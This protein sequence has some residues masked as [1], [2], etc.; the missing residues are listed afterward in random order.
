MRLKTT[1]FIDQ[2]SKEFGVSP[3]HIEVIINEPF[4]FMVNMIRKKENKSFRL[5]NLG[6]LFPKKSAKF[7]N[8]E[9]NRNIQS[10]QESN[11]TN[12]RTGDI[13]GEE[14]KDM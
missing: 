12:Y 14:T 5:H 10:I 3:K 4:R 1:D 11:N 6:I 8:N 2:L 13:G 9:D 7:E